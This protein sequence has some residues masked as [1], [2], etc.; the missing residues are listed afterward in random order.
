M[1]GSGLA[2]LEVRDGTMAV[3]LVMLGGTSFDGVS[4]SQ[5]W[6]DVVGTRRDWALTSVTTVGLLLTIAVV[7]LLYLVATRLL[8]LLA[9]D[10]ADPVALARLWAPS[11]V[12]IVLAYSLAHYFSLLVFEGQ[13]F[14]ALLSDPFG[15]GWDLFGTAQ[16]N[17]DFTVV[18]PNQIA[19]VQVA[20][21]VAGHVAGVVAA[22]DLA[23]GRYRHAVAVRS[24]Y[25][26][27]GVMVAYT[28]GGLLLLLNA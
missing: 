7:A 15:E 25:P 13:N 3:I 5:W 22:H 24:Q 28:V 12:P 20:A 8:G 17:I 14:L 10:D 27:L 19:Y 26:L 4:R 11:L 18:S 9:R 21:I 1:P 6:G 2:S 16:N 23:V